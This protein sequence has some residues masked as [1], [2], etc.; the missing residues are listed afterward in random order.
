LHPFFEDDQYGLVGDDG[1]CPYFWPIGTGDQAKHMLIHFSHMSGG[2]Y[3]LG[4]YDTERDKFVVTDG[5]DFNHGAVGPGGTHAPSAYPDGKGGVIAIFNMNPG[6]NTKGWNQI[7]SL[8]RRLTLSEEGKLDIEPGGDYASLRLDHQRIEGQA[9]PANKEFVFDTIRGNAME[10]I[11]EIDPGSSPVIELNVL[12]SPHEEEV[13]RIQY[14]HKRGFR[15]K[16]VP[17][18]SKKRFQEHGVITIDT[19]R[20]T[21]LPNVKIRPPETANVRIMNGETVKLHVF[22]DKSIVE[23]FVNGR[24]CAAVRVYPG[25]NESVGVS[26]CARGGDAKLKSLDAW[27]MDNIYK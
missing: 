11:A 8:P 3:M 13:T 1:A 27:Q 23:V 18:K 14:Y 15:T 22:V 17:R 2:K 20:S 4:D 10:L 7:M 26:L 25:L 6:M 21:T 12:R 9:L 19:S 24:Q 5:G 16:E